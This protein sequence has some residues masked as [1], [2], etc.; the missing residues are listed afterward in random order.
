M[1]ALLQASQ[2]PVVL[3]LEEVSSEHLGGQV[4]AIHQ[5]QRLMLMHAVPWWQVGSPHDLDLSVSGPVWMPVKVQGPQGLGVLHS[6]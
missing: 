3:L 2:Q 5:R 4:D 1:R 6:L